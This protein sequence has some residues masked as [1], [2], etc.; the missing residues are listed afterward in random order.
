MPRKH[1]TPPIEPQAHAPDLGLERIEFF[2][3]AVMAI[4]ITLLAI[5][6]RVPEIPA[7]LAAAQLPAALAELA[8]RIVS[9]VISFFVI[10]VYWSSHHRYFGHIRRYDNRL[11]FLNLLFLF[12]IVIMPFVAGLLG[13]FPTVPLAVAIYSGAVAATGYAIGG[14]WW[15]ASRNYR[16]IDPG[17]DL[18]YIHYTNVVAVTVPLFFLISIP[19]AFINVYAALAIWWI[20]PLVTRL[21]LRVVMNRPQKA[22]I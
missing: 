20:G 11:V 3:D 10:G 7:A 9:F 14:I 21:V 12:F 8:P 13:T 19:F 4:A 16:L 2:S 18:R 17:L 15:Y 1:R 5:D 22:M 6:L